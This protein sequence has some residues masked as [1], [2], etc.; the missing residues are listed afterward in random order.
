[1]SRPGRCYP[2]ERPG[3]HCTGGWV[4]PRPGL[5]R[6]GK[7]RLHR[8]SIPGSSSPQRVAIPRTLSRPLRVKD[9]QNYFWGDRRIPEASRTKYLV[10]ILRSDL[11]WADQVNYT[12]QNSRKALH[13]TMRVLKRG[14]STEFY[15]PTNALLCIIKYQ[16]KM[17]IL[18]HLKTLQHVSISFRSSSGSSNIL[19]KVTDFKIC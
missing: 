16:S 11:S 17:F 5:G 7:S 4:S 1:M 6:C 10:I 9:P 3:T 8:D 13:F 15:K 2:R 14:K 19:I 12:A 18:K